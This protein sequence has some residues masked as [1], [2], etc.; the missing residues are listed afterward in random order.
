MCT[1]SDAYKRISFQG[2]LYKRSK[3]IP[4]LKR[5]IIKVHLL[6]F[7]CQYCTTL[8]TSVLGYSLML[9]TVWPFE[10][11]SKFLIAFAPSFSANPR[12]L[13]IAFVL[14][15]SLIGKRNAVSHSWEKSKLP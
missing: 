7:S 2:S 14:F 4:H 9:E 1:L 11:L 6:F 15:K 5:G 12:N 3:I 8:N 13:L 10:R